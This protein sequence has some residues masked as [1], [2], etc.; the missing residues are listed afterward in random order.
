MGRYAQERGQVKE[1]Y[2]TKDKFYVLDITY[3]AAGEIDALK[4]INQNMDIVF[5]QYPSGKISDIQRNA[6]LKAMENAEVEMDK[7][8]EVCN[9][10]D[11]RDMDQN[12]FSKI[13]NKLQA[14][15]EAKEKAK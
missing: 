6:L 14:T 2:I 9:I 8:L 10:K 4:I 5:E 7:I 13:C 3:N 12:H 1:R 15:V 11:L